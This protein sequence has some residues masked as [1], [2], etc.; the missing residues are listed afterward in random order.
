MVSPEVTSFYYSICCFLVTHVLD[1]LPQ[2]LDILHIQTLF[3]PIDTKE[4]FDSSI[5]TLGQCHL[6][7]M[8]L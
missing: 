8:V 6:F 5:V 1:I 4:Q 7:F 2:T 3:L